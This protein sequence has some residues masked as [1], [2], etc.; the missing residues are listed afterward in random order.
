MNLD[1]CI[2]WYHEYK[3]IMWDFTVVILTFLLY[4]YVHYYQD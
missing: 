4:I 3:Q 2:E 1:K